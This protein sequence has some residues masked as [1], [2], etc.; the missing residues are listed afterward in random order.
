MLFRMEQTI[1][2]ENQVFDINKGFLETV[3]LWGR[4]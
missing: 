4:A 2:T 1:L 3:S